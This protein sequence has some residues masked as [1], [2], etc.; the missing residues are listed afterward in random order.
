MKPARLALTHNL[1]V[2]YGLHKKL[3]IFS[4]RRATDDEIASFHSE[5]YVDFLKRVT[6]DNVTNFTK[7][8][9]RFNVGVD[10]CP[11]FDG[12]YDFC[13]LYSGASIEAA[14]KLISTQSDIAINWSGGLHHAKKFEA[15][16]F[17]Y[18]NDIVL[19]IL[20]MLR[21][22]PRV[23][24]I[25]IDVHHGDGVQEAF[26]QTDRVMTCSFHRYDGL[27]FPGTGGVEEIGA[28]NGKHYSINVP[29][30]EYIDDDC[31][32]DV[33][34]HVMKNVMES[35]RPSCVVLQC[36]ADSLASD[37]LIKGHGA[38]VEYM[39][40]FKTPML[41]LGGG[42]YTIKNVSRCWAYETS[43]LVETDIP[44]ELPMTD[45]RSHYGPDYTLHPNITDS[46]L[47]NANSKQYLD[48]VKIKI[49]EYLRFLS[50][51]PGVQMQEVPPDLE[52]HLENGNVEVD[53]TEDLHS[54]TRFDGANDGLDPDGVGGLKRKREK[55]SKDIDERE[56]YEDDFDNDN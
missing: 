36:G 11:V 7:F 17:C 33:F 29:L 35:F 37:R 50:F 25:D 52:G 4:P 12:L 43:V 56:F 51:A 18:V 21:A 48:S 45:Y 23:L 6:P 24:Y 40:S 15:S 41:V 49:S 31:Y 1:V 28:Q 38:C 55:E 30:H 14:R 5:D 47:E 34:K 13:R 22:Y 27:F 53:Q 32:I 2:N 26:Y 16:G 44:N 54:D 42:G 10:D 46:T 20:E 8:L 9:T 3:D 39:K 19:A